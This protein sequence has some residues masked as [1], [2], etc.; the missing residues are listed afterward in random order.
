MQKKLH[1]I[2]IDSDK[3]SLNMYKELL[4]N[5]K[6]AVTTNSSIDHILDKIIE[7][8]PD[9]VI[10][11][12]SQST[13][14]HMQFYEELRHLK[15]I[16][17]PKFVATTDSLADL[18]SIRAY[19]LGMDGFFSKPIEPDTFVD[20]LQQII[21]RQM[22]VKFWGVR[23]TL[24]VPGKNTA[25]YGG[26]TN[27][28]TLCFAKKDLFIFD[29][30]TGIKELSNYLLKKDD[31]PMFARIFITHPHYDHINGIPFFMPLYMKG[32]QF[33]I[34]GMNHNGIGIEKLLA[35]Q[36]DNIH[37]PITMQEFSAQ[38]TF[39]N[40]QEEEFTIDELLI[41]TIKL[42]HPG[43]CIGFKVQYQNKV[44]CYIT[45]NELYLEDSPLY[46]QAD[47]DYLI[48]FIK[49]ANL[50]VMDATYSDKEYLKKVGWGHS[51]IS[52]VVDIADKA[53]V[54]TLC[55]FHHDPDQ[56]DSD[57]EAKLKHARSLLKLRGSNTICI[58]PREGDKIVI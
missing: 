42:N 20:D 50:V 12:F 11:D 57:I 49:D 34:Y 6:Y 21:D 16:K 27:C 55:L 7:T 4:E 51:C 19:E 43:C 17:Q 28:V 22:V 48:S 3:K 41:K 10:C 9:C 24:P 1:F 2:I 36:M 58:A 30:G 38:L 29:A 32:N 25:H 53:N 37:F 5:H 31:F 15:D 56:V 54:H 47:V 44:F 18:D 45:D 26:N 33:E 35:A 52:R 39:H 46:N 8:K 14:Q 40:L 13:A 23:G